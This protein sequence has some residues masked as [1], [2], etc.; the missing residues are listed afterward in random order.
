MSRGY[1]DRHTNY[2]RSNNLQVDQR[3]D[4]ITKGLSVK[5]MVTFF[6]K[7]YND[8]ARYFRP[9][10][11]T[12]SDYMI[13][14]DGSYDY[15]IH[16]NCRRTPVGLDLPG[17]MDQRLGIPRTQV[18]AS[19]NYARTFSDRRQRHAS[20]PPAQGS[21]TAAP[22]RP[23][24]TCCPSTEQD[25]P[26]ASPI[27][28][29]EQIPHGGQLRLQRQREFHP[30]APLRI[31]PSVAVGWVVSREGFFRPLT[32]VVNNLKFR[33]SYG[34]S[35]NDA[36]AA[37]FPYISTITMDNKLNVYF[38]DKYAQQSGP[39]ITLLGGS[40]LVEI[41]RKFN[42][43]MD[44]NMFDNSLSIIVDAFNEN[45]SGIF[46]QRVSLPSSMGY[47]G[48]TSYGNIGKVRNY[49]VDGSPRIRP[50]LR[51]GPDRLRARNVHLCPQRNG[52]P[53]RGAGHGS[54]HAAQGP[55][56]L[57]ALGTGR[58]R[59][60][61]LAGGDRQQPRADLFRHGAPGRHQI[62]RSE[63]RR[64]DR[65]QR[66]DLDRPPDDPRNLRRLRRQHPVQRI[67]LLVLLPGHGALAGIEMIDAPV[68]RRPVLRAST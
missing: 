25:S 44:L 32:K 40:F 51:Q 23:R 12:L 63:R 27:Q 4:F 68:P 33:V 49:G 57:L 34:E 65:R 54:L 1:K 45:R 66:P 56:D 35:G 48:E 19:A 62:P 47:T 24:P 18:Q 7:T 39:G 9:F 36:L 60:F 3:L 2:A 16:P 10:Y 15:S 46:M 59:T 64:R 58:R 6:N 26:D 37:R 20:L 53:R 17:N 43:G 13:K 11:Y 41:S 30:R 61:R 29:Q 31:F 50:G 52:F 38:G 8:V 14:D 5:G 55:A 22:R 21:S 67:R 42:A 28:L